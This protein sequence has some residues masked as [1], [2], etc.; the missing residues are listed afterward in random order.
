MNIVDMRRAEGEAHMEA[1]LAAIREAPNGLTIAEV[2]AATDVSDRRAR[3]YLGRLA[4]DGEVARRDGRFVA[5]EDLPAGHVVDQLGTTSAPAPAIAPAHDRVAD[6]LLGACGA[7]SGQVEARARRFLAEHEMP[8]TDENL[9]AAVFDALRA[10]ARE[11][12]DVVRQ[13]QDILT[14]AQDEAERVVGEA[15]EEAARLV[16]A[17]R[18]EAD[19][20]RAS[21]SEVAEAVEAAR[22]HAHDVVVAGEKAASEAL[23]DRTRMLDDREQELALGAAALVAA[24]EEVARFRANE[25]RQ[26]TRALLAELLADLRD[27][28]RIST[29]E[30]GRLAALARDAAGLDP[31][32]AERGEVFEDRAEPA[33]PRGNVEKTNNEPTNQNHQNQTFTFS[34]LFPNV[35]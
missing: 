1:I 30:A 34:A 29:R 10:F 9:T 22:Q 11:G 28:P 7:L 25:A 16:A 33:E 12:L 6:T 8:T 14:G 17:A 2:V 26:A 19:Q 32:G 18:A 27:A 4:V 35:R 23:A 24:F 15:R 3:E 21:V 31:L 20:V 5:I 13:A